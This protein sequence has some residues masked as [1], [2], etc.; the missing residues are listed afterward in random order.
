M[1]NDSPRHVF[2]L[3]CSPKI[4]ISIAYRLLTPG[5]SWNVDWTIF[6]SSLLILLNFYRSAIPALLNQRILLKFWNVL[7]NLKRLVN[8][9]TKENFVSIIC[10]LS[11]EIE[12]MLCST[13]FLMSHFWKKSQRSWCS[14]T[15]LSI[16]S[17]GNYLKFSTSFLCCRRQ[18]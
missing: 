1:V 3:T 14:F 16:Y 10:R 17:V 12:H 2:Q 4:N 18:C 8:C 6:P 7:V 11:I 13:L 5:N 9:G 15:K